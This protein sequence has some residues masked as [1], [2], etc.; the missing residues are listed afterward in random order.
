M[1]EL[2]NHKW[3]PFKIGDIFDINKCDYGKDNKY[4][5]TD[6]ISDMPVV[7]GQTTNNGVMGYVK[8][9]DIKSKIYKD[10]LTISTRGQYSGTVLYHEGEFTLN[11]NI[12]I[13]ALKEDKST[14]VKLFLQVPLSN[15]GYGVTIMNAKGGYT[16][17]NKKILMC[18]VPTRQYYEIKTMIEEIDKDV[19]FLITDTYEIYGGM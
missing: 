8:R 16:N 2:L 5:L 19:F 10:C 6:N 15:L 4:E 14:Y 1:A 11:N 13:L 7:S 17:K 12:M 9:E 3:A 18:S